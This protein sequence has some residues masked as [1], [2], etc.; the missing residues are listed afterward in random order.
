MKNILKVSIFVLFAI[1]VISCETE[2][3]PNVSANGFLLRK[4]SSISTPSILLSNDDTNI[5][6]KLD[7]DKSDNGPQSVATYTLVAFDHDKD[8]NLM[9]PVEYS[10]SGL[11]ITATSRNAT[12][13]VK[14]FNELINKLTT[15]KCS[16]MNI[17]VRIKSVLGA[18][19]ET[20]FIQ[21]SSPIN[22]K[23]TGYSTKAPILAFVKE[24]NSA[25]VSTEPKLVASA[26]G[27]NTDYEG[28]MYLQSGDYKF[29]QPDACG[30]FASA[31]AI[32]G[33]A[34]TLDTDSA[35]PSITVAT[36]GYYL[37]K[38]NIDANTYSVSQY[39]YFGIYGKAKSTLFS[40]RAFPF[41]DDDHDN[42][43]T[44]TVELFKGRKFKLKSNYWTTPLT[45]TPP[46][47]PST[48]PIISALGK[49]STPGQLVNV[50]SNLDDTIGLITVPGTDDGTKVTCI[51]TIDVRNS[52]DYKYTLVTQ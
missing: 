16:E 12:L 2:I 26:A 51:I 37:V 8:P 19:P 22:F 15:Y 7:W 38:A 34:G 42:V 28:Y 35:A 20:A 46:Y 23:V 31:T 6:A 27:V 29:Y 45:G 33:T 52:R 4:D 44:I 49:S 36:A 25:N 39:N 18:N 41:A 24:G 10:G 13:T 11:A 48:A 40:D 14:E 30:D 32:G 9:N 17:D 1:F 43:W 50:S 21:Y 47:I 3:D 5:F